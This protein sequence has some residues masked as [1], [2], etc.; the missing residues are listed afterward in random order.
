MILN[1]HDFEKLP[2]PPKH[3]LWFLRGLRDAIANDLIESTDNEERIKDIENLCGYLW[4]RPHHLKDQLTRSLLAGCS[5]ERFDLLW[6]IIKRIARMEREA[7]PGYYIEQYL[8]T[9]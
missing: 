5:A 7:I 2:E 9:A 6:F 1:L 3:T 8:V 4:A